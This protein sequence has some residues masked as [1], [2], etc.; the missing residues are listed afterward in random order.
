MQRARPTMISPVRY[1]GR[2]GSK[3]QASTN[4]TAGP[5]SQLRTREA[6]SIRRSL[7]TDPSRPYRTFAST[8]YI[9]TRRPMKIGSEVPEV[10]WMALR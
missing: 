10:T 4:M 6:P 3:S 2:L 5:T 8:G 9:I 7:V 1:A